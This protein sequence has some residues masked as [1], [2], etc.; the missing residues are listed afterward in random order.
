MALHIKGTQVED[1]GVTLQIYMCV[2]DFVFICSGCPVLHFLPSLYLLSTYPMNC[3]SRSGTTTCT[4]HVTSAKI[5]FL[6]PNH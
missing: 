3:V 2:I 1:T 6:F 5:Q 4:T